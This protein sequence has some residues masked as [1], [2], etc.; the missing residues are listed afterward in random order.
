M[1][2]KSKLLGLDGQLHEEQSYAPNINI[3]NK[4]NEVK[5]GMIMD[6]IENPNETTTEE[7]KKTMDEAM[8]KLD[9]KTMQRLIQYQNR[10]PS[11]RE[12]PK[13]GRNDPCPC[14]SGKKYKNCC[15]SSG[16][17]EKLIKK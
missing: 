17:F 2:K 4:E 13:I 1:Q 6:G 15:L 12:Y 11:V 14:G 16:K 7:F 5:T 10:K 9:E 8:P 3:S